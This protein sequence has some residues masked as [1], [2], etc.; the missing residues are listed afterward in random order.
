SV[1]MRNYSKIQFLEINT[2][3][4]DI[5]GEGIGVITS[6]EQNTLVAVLYERRKSPILFQRGRLAESVIENSHA[7]HR[8]S[9]QYT[10]AQQQDRC[11]CKTN[12]YS[13]SHFVSFHLHD[14]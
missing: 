9:G 12:R 6:I 13:A 14:G 5:L 4:F 7:I 10:C 11:S 2:Q 1:P 8:L 3:C